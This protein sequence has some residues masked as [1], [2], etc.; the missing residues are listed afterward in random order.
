[1][2]THKEKLMF[3]ANEQMEIF[4]CLWSTSLN[5]SL[6]LKN[7]FVHRTKLNELNLT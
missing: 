2:K 6:S 4:H 5:H 3:S 1:M 7:H